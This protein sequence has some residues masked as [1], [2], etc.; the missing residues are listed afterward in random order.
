VAVV[1]SPT[2]A[3]IRDIIQV[4][5]RRRDRIVIRV[6]PVPVQGDGAGDK[7]ARAITYA[8]RHHLADTLIVGRGGGSLED[9]LPFSDESVVRAIAESVI[10]VISAVGHETDWALSDYAADLRAPTPSAAAEMVSLPTR[11]LVGTIRRY[12]NET[13]RS[14]ERIVDSLRARLSRFSE[15]EIRYRFRNFVQPWYQRLDEAKN[16]I[17]DGVTRR[18]TAVQHR[19]QIAAERL[20]ALSP[21]EPLSRGYVLV[22]RDQTNEIVIDAAETRV[23]ELLTIQFRD[24]TILVERK[25]DGRV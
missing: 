24:G 3:A 6:L 11:D 5:R 9:L 16:T 15:D 13:L 2:G 10:P 23:A 18:L 8:S 21:Y 7:I 22:R 25:D 19:Y 4:L 14:Y 1:T 20:V 12:R 17:V